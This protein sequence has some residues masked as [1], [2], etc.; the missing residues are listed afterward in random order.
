MCQEYRL[1]LG[2]CSK[3]IIFDT[4]LTT[5][6]TNLFFKAAGKIAKIGSSL[7]P[8]HHNKVKIVEVPDT[9]CRISRN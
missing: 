3:I 1:N 8:N 6:D 7:K 4:L 5:F 9:K 2:K